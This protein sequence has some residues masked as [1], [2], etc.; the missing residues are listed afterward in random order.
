MTAGGLSLFLLKVTEREAVEQILLHNNNNNNNN[1][2]TII[3]NK[4]LEDP[5]IEYSTFI[6][7]R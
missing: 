6:S 1:R 3:I 4:G 5:D 2:A 7:V